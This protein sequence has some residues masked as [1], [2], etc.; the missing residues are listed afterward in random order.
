MRV[1]AELKRLVD[2][3]IPP[4]LRQP[5][6]QHLRARLLVQ[7]LLVSA[8]VAA[9]TTCVYLATAAWLAFAQGVSL[10]AVTLGA[11]I[12]LRQMGAY[13]FCAYIPLSLAAATMLAVPL[14]EGSV[15]GAALAW[16]C[17]I[18]FAAVVLLGPRAAWAWTAVAVTTILA[19]FF[20]PAAVGETPALPPVVTLARAVFL[21]AILAG[22][23]VVLVSQQ[24]SVRAELERISRAKSSFL[25]TVSHEIRTP[26]NGVLGMTDVMLQ[27][28]TDETV[29]QHLALMAHS[30]QQMITLVSTI[31]D[32]AKI[33][34]GALQLDAQDFELG[35]WLEH[36]LGPHRGA[37][38]R[39]GLR[40]SARL[41]PGTPPRICADERRLAQVLGHLVGNGVRFTD[42]GAVGVEVE[43]MSLPSSRIGLRFSVR[44]TGA[45]VAPE[46]Q[47]RLFEPFSQVDG[48]G[49]Q[50]SESTG[51]GLS[52]CRALVELMGGHLRVTSAPGLGTCISFELGVR[53]STSPSR[54]S[55]PALEPVGGPI[56]RGT[57]LVVDDEAV[58]RTV[59]CAL[60]AKA[61]YGCETAANGVEAVEVVQRSRYAVVLM[62]CQMPD[63]DGL[64]AARRIRALRGAAGRTPLV[65]LTGSAIPEELAACRDA[66]LTEFLV[67]PL[68][69]AALRLVL[70]RVEATAAA[71]AKARDS[72]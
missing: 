63:M 50:R 39:K 28:E 46:L 31:L 69:L 57:A 1:A 36:I 44:D 37:A 58:N 51:V 23:A 64:E 45:G 10:I 14:Y 21:V 17:V 27:D 20:S 41:A 5:F 49:A 12:L 42:E 16:P 26:M 30:G 55:A 62:N 48:S 22:F 66:G 52:L 70:G 33:E 11:L 35:E 6:E 60:L 7:V 29:R 38:A 72:E 34:A 59:A 18:P 67:K 40:L 61:G 47:S 24:A 56:V 9:A 13:R 32:L 19:I 15:D 3:W 71:Q 43:P 53:L 8:L 2:W 68:S 25:A 4:T 65:A 54:T